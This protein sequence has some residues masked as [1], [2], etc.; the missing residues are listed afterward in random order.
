MISPAFEI[1]VLMYVYPKF[2]RDPSS[3]SRV[4]TNYISD[5]LAVALSVNRNPLVLTLSPSSLLL[6]N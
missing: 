3:L 1:C 2:E 5:A 4:I 6:K